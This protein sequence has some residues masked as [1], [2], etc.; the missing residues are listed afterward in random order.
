[1]LL[2]LWIGYNLLGLCSFLFQF[3]LL[4]QLKS[5]V[6]VHVVV[7]IA[8]LS[9][10]QCEERFQ[11]INIVLVHI[12]QI[13]L[14]CQFQ[15]ILIG[16]NLIA[17]VVMQVLLHKIFQLEH[18]EFECLP[19]DFGISILNRCELFFVLRLGYYPEISLEMSLVPFTL[20]QRVIEGNQQVVEQQIHQSFKQSLHR[21]FWIVVVFR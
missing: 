21:H 7:V 5:V 13:V 11:D 19:F 1:M 4:L 10:L 3:P 8:E 9:L 14:F 2:I 12:L 18:I 20:S 6:E 17:F 15:F 16:F